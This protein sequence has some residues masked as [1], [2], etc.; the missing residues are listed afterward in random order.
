MNHI[1]NST[2]HVF[3]LEDVAASVVMTQGEFQKSFFCSRWTISFKRGDSL[4]STV[5]WNPELF[6]FVLHVRKWN[7]E[8]PHPLVTDS[9]NKDSFVWFVLIGKSNT[10][11]R[12]KTSRR[13]LFIIG[14]T[15]FWISSNTW[16]T[17]TNLIFDL[18]AFEAE[19]ICGDDEEH[20]PKTIN[21]LD[22][23]QRFFQEILRRWE[24]RLKKWFWKFFGPTRYRK[25]QN[26]LGVPWSVARSIRPRE[27][28][29]VAD[30]YS[31]YLSLLCYRGCCFS[32]K[33]CSKKFGSGRGGP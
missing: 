23:N 18:Y 16:E 11:F 3:Y 25:S 19:Y 15:L 7:S 26:F 4:K 17:D 8:W 9:R 33:I 32:L 2:G 1:G 20:G 5:A 24:L 29:F 12:Q 14:K 31:C 10:M 13:Y 28:E 22:P 6:D 27:L 30:A 21:H